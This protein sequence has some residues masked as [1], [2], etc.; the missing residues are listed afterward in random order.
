MNVEVTER[1]VKLKDDG[2]FTQNSRTKRQ[3]YQMYANSFPITLVAY[4]H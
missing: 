4:H 2:L 1:L 3:K